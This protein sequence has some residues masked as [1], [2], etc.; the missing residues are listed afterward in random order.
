MVVLQHERVALE[1]TQR[2]SVIIASNSDILREGLQSI[3]AREPGLRL[4]GEARSNN[5]TVRL[6]QT[7]KPDIVLL[8]LGM[9]GQEPAEV[10]RQIKEVQPNSTVLVFADERELDSLT[11]LVGLGAH[12]Y[13]L[14]DISADHLLRAIDAASQGFM[15]IDPRLLAKAPSTVGQPS[16][17]GRMPQDSMFSSLSAKERE[18]LQLL[19]MGKINEEIAEET[20]YSL[21]M[22]KNI[23]QRIFNKLGVSNR[24]QAAILAYKYGLVE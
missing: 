15:V 16:A 13:M 14:K 20:H 3:L 21:S 17:K 8:A 12:G 1:A 22:V 18:V 2:R 10:V 19:A 6:V 4:V 7:L 23:L 24:I 5:E 9:S 11:R